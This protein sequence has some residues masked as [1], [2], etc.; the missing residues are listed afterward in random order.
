MFLGALRIGLSSPFHLR[1]SLDN[2]SQWKNLGETHRPTSVDARAEA[3]R[4]ALNVRN[5]S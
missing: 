4:H 2:E 5:Q 3:P 1:K